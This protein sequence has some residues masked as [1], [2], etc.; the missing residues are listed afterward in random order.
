[1]RGMV[2]PELTDYDVRHVSEIHAIIQ[3]GTAYVSGFI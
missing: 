2:V 3:E 1:M